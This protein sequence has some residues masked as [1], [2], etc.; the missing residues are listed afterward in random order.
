VL[1]PPVGQPF[2]ADTQVRLESQPFE[3]TISARMRIRY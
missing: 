3:G 2:Q 1:R